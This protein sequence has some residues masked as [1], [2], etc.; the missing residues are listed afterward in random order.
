VVPRDGGDAAE[1]EA[2]SVN[3]STKTMQKKW[4]NDANNRLKQQ[5]ERKESGFNKKEKGGKQH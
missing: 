3:I 2:K 5:V 4:E 1:A